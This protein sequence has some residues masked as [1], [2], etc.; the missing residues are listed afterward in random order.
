MI[1]TPF[2][3]Q[4]DSRA[5]IKGSRD[6][7]GVQPIWAR[8]GR[9]VVANLTT[10]S[11]SVHDFTV[12][13][14]GYYFAERVAEEGGT[15]GD[16]ST[17]LKWE[18]LAAYARA[19]VNDERGF[20]G[21]ERVTR[22]LNDG[23]RIHLGLDASAQILS[24]QK[25]YG[26]WGLY[27]VPAKA[28]GL[29]EGNPTRLTTD[30]RIVVEKSL[31]PV[32]EFESPRIIRDIVGLL[33]PAESIFDFHQRSR[34]IAVVNAVGLLFKELRTPERDLYREHLL[35]GGPPDQDATRGAQG[36]QKVFA[37]LLT[38]TLD[39]S[40]WVLTPES[41]FALAGRARRRGAVGGLV[42][43][44]LERIRSAEL[45]LAPAAALFEHAMGCDDQSPAQ[46]ADDVRQHWGSELRRT[47]ST[48]AI[49]DLEMELRARSDDPESGHRWTKLAAAFCDARYEDAL[50]LVLEQNAAVMKAR[51]AA[52][53]WADIR[54]GKLNV[55]FRDEQMARLPEAEELP[56][57]WRHAYFIESLRNVAAALRGPN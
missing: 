24:N 28:S 46:I 1:T 7:L 10:V 51:A 42:A 15:E 49:E 6:P 36:K 25:T 13:L 31:L 40:D 3:T 12:L 45:L 55:R 43:T 2:L 22:R 30:A 41:I 54:N 8:L 20:R 38:E 34:D 32:L 53:P 37:E 44:K 52:A 11:N 33:R 21:T 17:F 35:Y 57:Y 48:E 27:T 16:L 18:Q 5:A 19:H 29:L 47:I 39:E 9:H 4:L 26:L 14:L 23:E 56:G 50:R